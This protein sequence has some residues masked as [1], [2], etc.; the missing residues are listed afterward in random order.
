MRPSLSAHLGVESTST[1]YGAIYPQHNREAL[2]LVSCCVMTGLHRQFV[3][4]FNRVCYHKHRTV[5]CRSSFACQLVVQRVLLSSLS[6][7]TLLRSSMPAVA[8]AMD[9]YL[10]TTAKTVY[11]AFGK[12][13][14]TADSNVLVQGHQEQRQVEEVQS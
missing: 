1:A 9:S 8:V 5:T 6:A 10:T 3:S 11:A 12:S 7:V 14:A 4:L 13:F 2:E